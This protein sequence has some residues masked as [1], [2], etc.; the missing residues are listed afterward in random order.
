MTLEEIKKKREKQSPYIAGEVA[1]WL[2]A[3]VERL[4]RRC[5]ELGTAYSAMTE[6]YQEA[7]D[8]TATSCAEIAEGLPDKKVYP[9]D[10]P[11]F[12]LYPAPAKKAADV[13]RKEFGLKGR[14]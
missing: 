8:K 7:V 13:I 2:I 4:Q 9:T 1:D 11:W 6:M 12:V 10:R 5:E 14:E 3:E